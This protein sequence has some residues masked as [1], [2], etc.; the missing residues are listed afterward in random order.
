MKL[1]GF[2]TLMVSFSFPCILAGQSTNASLTGVVDDPSKA[3][4]AGVSITAINT[5]TGVKS[6]TTTNGSG[7]YVLPGLIPGSY[8]VEVDKQGFKGI[9]ESGLI[10][11]V[12]DVVQL[13]FH[14]AI[15][16]MS[17]TVSVS[18]DSVNIN[19]TDASVSTV[20]D[21][22][23]VENLPLNGRSFQSLLYVTPGVSLN[24]GGGPSSG[25]SQGQFVV[26]GQRADANYWM[27][28]GVSA[29]AGMGS[30]ASGGA[31]GGSLG[32][33]N[34]LGGTSALVSVDALQEF[35]I[36][37]STYAPEFGRVPGGQISIET[38]SGTNQFHGTI[39]DYLRNG[40]LDAKDWFADNQGLSKPA[41]IQNDFGGVV[42]GPIFR[43]KTFFFFSAEALRLTLPYTFI[44]TV[45]DMASRA[46][47]IPA[48]QPY[49]NAYPIPKPGAEDTISGSGYV[50]YSATYSEP[51]S[52][53]AYSL[54][55]DHQ[56]LS[57]LSLFARYNYAPSSAKQRGGSYGYAANSI[58]VIRSVTK[59]VTAGATWTMSSR[60]VDDGR[61]NYTV[62]AGSWRQF[63]D[64][65]GG[66]T[67]FP[68]Q[69]LFPSPFTYEDSNLIFTPNFGSYMT[70]FNGYVTSNRQHQYNAVDTLSV[71]RGSHGLKFGIDYR[72]LTPSWNA[73]HY[74]LLPFFD[75]MRDLESGNSSL[76]I[77]YQAV[78]QAFLLHNLGVFAQD[79]WRINN[80]LN[81][82]YG[83][84]W[85]VD[86]APGSRM[87]L[88]FVTLTGYNTPNLSG[89][90]L[91][92]VGTAPYGTRY[93][94]VAPRVGGAYRVLSDPDWGLVLRGGF[95]VYY[96]LATTEIGNANFNNLY[97]PF[98]A[99]GVSSN[100]AFPTTPDVA[101][102]PPVMVPNS[103]NGE[104]LAGFDPYLN[105]PY[106]LEWN[107]ALE[108]SLGQAQTFTLSYIGASDKR[109]LGSEFIT[110]PNPNYAAANL[111][112]NSGSSNFEALQAK[113]QRRL[114]KGLQ[115]LV[116]YTW[117]H[118]ID[119]GSY[120]AY[121]NGSFAGT[122]ANR[123]DSDY[124]LREVFSAALTYYIPEWRKNFLTRVLTSEWSTDNVVQ[125]RS[126]PPL[127][128]QDANFAD[129]SHEN[130]SVLIRPDVVFGQPL[131]LTGPQYPGHK[132]LNPASFTDPPTLVDPTTG[133]PTPTRQGDL[134]RNARR[135]PGL[136]QWD[137]A[138][139]RDFPIFERVR[140]QFRAELFNILNH[141]NF[142]PF[143]NQ[144]ETQLVNGI[145]V[146]SNP[147][148]GQSTQ[149]LNVY[150]G[151]Q[152]GSGS[153]NP[154][155]TP[156]SPRS[157]EL[158]LKLVF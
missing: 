3:A 53:D 1:I 116:S 122:N 81:L 17:E 20:I 9:I 55:I 36:Q 134:G 37:T 27:V 105:L 77:T 120:G 82:T 85:D 84:R 125:V 26:N 2:V 147:V 79:T 21:R 87:G 65:F 18:G 157:G 59:S 156:G 115:S 112:G 49:L 60:I 66:G 72:R 99:E 143:N 61:F 43:D 150:L 51:D 124:D 129:I 98:G 151:G 130:A 75:N 86:F 139:H 107:V 146:I 31:V 140:L 19:T 127:D 29:N 12:Q 133:L 71:Q 102:L 11:H 46:T 89:L 64:D 136:A 137:F 93:G 10:L 6:T 96:G 113:F 4:I 135:S 144:F 15:G 73:D 54:R 38:R 33:T 121:S 88:G 142:G 35:R 92:S 154:L 57:N 104:T 5:E 45:P 126:G 70:E 153:Q 34:A 68:G 78:P 128:V 32:A 131:Y 95:G 109:M 100:V 42:G 48:V 40:D 62:A 132:A 52:A 145:S 63:T 155:Y 74:E 67:P 117:S 148:F 118:S 90:A 101:A 80:R 149:M 8:R 25:Y 97:F 123:G 56:L 24:V 14:M 22:Q 69:S 83:L 114:A 158:A 16:S 23:F 41:E 108:Q 47:A 141:P 119:N 111:I 7:Q 76:T 30:G 103:Q 58:A 91:A 39:F 106:A 138:A 50:P 13:N 94:N 28:D 110:N 44:G 152:A